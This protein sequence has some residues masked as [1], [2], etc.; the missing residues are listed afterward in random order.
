MRKFPIGVLLNSFRTTA[1]EA[2]ER[3]VEIG[4][5][6]IQVPV[7]HGELCYQ[8]LT[9][10]KRR[11]FVKQVA[12]KGLAIS[13]VCGDIGAFMNA[14]KNKEMIENSKRIMDLAK[15]MGANIVTTH[16]GVVPE[17][18]KHPRYRVMQ[19]ACFELAGYADSLDAHFAIETGPERAT[20][21]KAFLDDLHST[22]V[23]VNL[24]PAN[25]AMVVADDPVQAVYTLRDYIVH[26][27]AKDGKQ[28]FYKDPEKI[29]G[30]CEDDESFSESFL[31]T[32]LGEGNVDYPNY[33]KALEDIGYHGFLTIEREV[34]ENPSEDIR[35]AV[36]F[37][38]ETMK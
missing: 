18:P 7:A 22:G 24:D 29:Y 17:D 30:V 13:A 6:G 3:V 26:T 16:I 1:A 33:L 19:E 15:E 31:E 14:E 12:D 20:V 25:L 35:R 2:L 28:L 27:H 38:K 9:A 11:E 5:V 4:A 21:L 23:A 32:P 10:E 8:T 34:G 36:T 37:L